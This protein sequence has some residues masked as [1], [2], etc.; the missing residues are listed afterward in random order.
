MRQR[1]QGIPA[2]NAPRAP[3]SPMV[4]TPRAQPMD[5]TSHGLGSFSA[6]DLRVEQHHSSMRGQRYLP[7]FS[8]EISSFSSKAASPKLDQSYS[9]LSTLFSENRSSSISV[10]AWDGVNS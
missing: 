8:N 5:S 6:Y 2:N 9:P 10:T 1:A 7:P 4:Q 3:T